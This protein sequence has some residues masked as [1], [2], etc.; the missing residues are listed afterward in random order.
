MSVNLVRMNFAALAAKVETT[1]GTDVFAGTVGATEWIGGDCEVS[2][3][4]DVIELSEYTGSIDKAASIVGG[5]KPRLRIRVPLRGSGAAA[6]E[7]SWAALVKASA[8][9]VTA[10]GSA[11]GAPTAAASGTTTTVTAASP[12]GTTAQQYRGMPLLVTGDQSFTTGIIDYTAGRV[13]T[14]GETR[15]SGLTVSSLLQI[16]INNLYSPTSD[17]TAYKS[18]TVYAYRDGL[19]WAFAGCKGT[20]SIEFTT[21]GLGFLTFDMQASTV[22]KSAASLPAG[23][24]TAASA[25]ALIVPP[26]LVNTKIQLNKANAQVKSLTINAGVNVML[27]EDPEGADGYGLPVP[28][29]RDTSGSLDPFQNTTNAVTLFTAFKSGTAMSLMA[30]IGSTAG[31]R[32]LAVVP[33]V[34]NTAMDPGN[35]GGL[36][37]H[38]M[39]FQA[40]GADSAFYLCAF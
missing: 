34:R 25:R 33:L 17:E 20:F 32:F 9:A 31:N 7:P 21:A 39:Q 23:A 36:A 14:F 37:T 22:V 15:G 13:I 16:P 27:P 6:T 1:D 35:R 40:D 8:Y 26:R 18:A 11:V 10:T 12:F 4:P 2:F 3:N 29:E 28:I 5:L 30:L 24:A 19:L 38:G